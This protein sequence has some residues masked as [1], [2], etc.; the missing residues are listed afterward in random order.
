MPQVE[1]HF[2]VGALKWTKFVD[3]KINCLRSNRESENS[4]AEELNMKKRSWSTNS[5][6]EDKT[7]WFNSETILAAT[8][9]Q[10]EEETLSRGSRVNTDWRTQFAEN[11]GFNNL[12]SPGIEPRKIHREMRRSAPETPWEGRRD[13]QDR[14]QVP[15]SPYF[16]HYHFS[17]QNYIC[18]Y[19]NWSTFSMVWFIV[20]CS[21]LK[22]T[23]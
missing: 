1:I 17:I 15:R 10:N 20:Q 6:L 19:V 2:E 8:K 11:L 16:C 4:V 18:M 5:R 9:G 3:M 14:S 22:L 13:H 23:V 7:N 21:Y 12:P